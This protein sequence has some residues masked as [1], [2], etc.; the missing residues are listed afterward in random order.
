MVTEQKHHD[1]DARQ[2]SEKHEDGLERAARKIDPPGWEQTNEDLRDPGSTTPG[3]TP[4]D[5]RS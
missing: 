2:R 4:T 5:N 1:R 3:A